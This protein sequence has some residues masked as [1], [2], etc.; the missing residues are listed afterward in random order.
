MSLP[1]D[2]L[3][4]CAALLAGLGRRA[5]PVAAEL[6]PGP[7]PAEGQDRSCIDAGSPLLLSLLAPGGRG[8]R[9]QARLSARPGD[10]GVLRWLGR[11]HGPDGSSEQWQTAI[12]TAETAAS[13]RHAVAAAR[14]AGAEDRLRRDHRVL[15]P[16][17]R[18]YA[19]ASSLDEP[20]PRVAV[21]WLMDRD[22]RP[23]VVLEACG[24]AA[25]WP[26]AAE[27]VGELLGTPAVPDRG[28]WSVR[29]SLHA[30]PGQVRI[31]TTIWARRIEDD[32]KRRRLA[33]LVER[34]SGDAS[35]AEALY[36]LIEA[37]RPAGSRIGRAVE[38]E[39]DGDRL[40]AAEFFLSVAAPAIPGRSTP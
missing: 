10:E 39:V 23:A 25:A 32:A 38:V 5:G 21:S 6:Q 31:G 29:R 11:H 14:A 15:G 3:L 33:R 13:W 24:L 4:R 8:L 2:E 12:Y 7:G 40:V 1:P 35:Y 17:G 27:V 36:K 26:V 18:V 20:V 22:A 30:G 28:P 19:V 16:A 37:G 9:V 34:L